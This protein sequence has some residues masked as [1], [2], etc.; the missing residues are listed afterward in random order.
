MDF[1]NTKIAFQD[2]NN[3][4]LN[5][6]LLL[7]RTIEKPW[8][9]KTGKIMLE[10]ALKTRLPIGWATKP[11]IYRHFVGGE[12]LEKCQPVV[13]TMAKSNVKSILDY[14]VEGKSTEQGIEN[15][16]QETLRSIENAGKNE[17]IPF[18]V[19][20][21]TAMVDTAVLK[22]ISF[23]QKITDDEQLQYK[24]FADRIDRLSSAAADNNI[25]LLIDAEDYWFQDAIDEVVHEMMEKYNKHKVIVFN[26]LQMYRTDRLEY[27]KNLIARARE[28]KFYSGVKFVRGAYMEKER[29]RAKEEGYP[30]PINPDK[31]T[32]DKM[33]D[34]ALRVS[35]E[36]IDILHVFNGTHNEQSNILLTELI[37]DQGLSKDDDRIYFSQLYGMSDHISYNLANDGYNV[38]KY[39]PYGPVRHVAPYL[40][41]RAEENTSVAGQTGRELSLILKEK[42]RRKKL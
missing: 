37:K 35:M 13:D 11:T 6:A 23:K 30:S 39:I 1:N 42:Q 5:R 14:S 26:T 36:N 25:R 38:A 29:A 32:T 4:D 8:M 16:F 31:G 15:A 28:R 20:K 24:A 10:V 12:T 2:K 9:V 40:I 17:N 34:D 41:R 27:L 22:K 7:F 21:P 3:A 33:Y 18:A 19:F